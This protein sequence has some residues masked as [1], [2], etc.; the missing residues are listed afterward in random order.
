MLPALLAIAGRAASAAGSIGRAAAGALSRKSIGS[1]AKRVGRGLLGAK[2]FKAASRKWRQASLLDRVWI[3][4]SALNMAETIKSKFDGN[5]PSFAHTISVA[6]R[7]GPEADLRRIWYLCLSAAFGRYRNR[8]LSVQQVQ[9]EATWDIT[10]KACSVTIGYSTSGLVDQ[11]SRLASNTLALPTVATGIGLIQRGPDQVTVGGNW[12]AFMFTHTQRTNVSQTATNIS[13]IGGLLLNP[14]AA[15]PLLVTVPRLLRLQDTSFQ[16]NTDTAGSDWTYQQGSCS[17]RAPLPLQIFG[18]SG[19]LRPDVFR[20]LPRIR[21]LDTLLPWRRVLPNGQNTTVSFGSV[22]S[23]TGKIP[24]LPDDGRLITT[25][26]KLDPRAQ[27]P[28]P[29]L[30]GIGRSSAIQLVTQALQSPCFLVAP[31][32]CAVA[33]LG[34]PGIRLY[35]A[36]QGTKLLGLNDDS[37]TAAIQPSTDESTSGGFWGNASAIIAALTG[38]FRGPDGYL[39]PPEEIID[40]RP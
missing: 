11:V 2:K 5:L 31:P 4:E 39:E 32:P 10:G 37:I 25:G 28:R 26:E 38:R 18:G 36:G 8:A 30:D 24:V 23:F 27:N 40:L 9:L 14:V 29:Q 13:M 1:I 3:A 22:Q 16:I 21:M 34:S 20:E 19:G 17:S 15:I 12:P 33:P 35:P 7:G 6:V